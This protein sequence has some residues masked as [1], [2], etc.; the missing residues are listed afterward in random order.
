M[1]D[2]TQAAPDTEHGQSPFEQEMASLIVETLHLETSPQDIAPEA[3][4]FGE[5]LGLDSIDALELSLA[6]SRAYGV[7]LKSDD[8]ENPAIFASLRA[9]A[10]HVSAHRA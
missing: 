2:H 10:A 6:I 5:G 4:L 3:R 8:A 7:N 1:T 9:L